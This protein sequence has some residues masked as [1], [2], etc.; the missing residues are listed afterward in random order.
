MRSKLQHLLIGARTAYLE[1][2]DPNS[3]T[4][5]T[6]RRVRWTNVREASRITWLAWLSLLILVRHFNFI[7][8]LVRFAFCC[9]IHIRIQQDRL[10]VPVRTK[11]C[12]FFDES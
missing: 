3:F 4:Q 1:K 12:L 8:V 11:F 2:V 10:N 5:K 7:R 9:E 6:I